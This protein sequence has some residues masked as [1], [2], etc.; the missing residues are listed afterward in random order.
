MDGL[1]GLRSHR[2]SIRGFFLQLLWG[3]GDSK[4]FVD[5]LL[6]QIL[7]LHV[8]ASSLVGLLQR[9]PQDPGMANI[10]VLSIRTTSVSQA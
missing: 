7:E 10:Y 4:H 1:L 2:R 9:L 6:G 5:I 3:R 8:R